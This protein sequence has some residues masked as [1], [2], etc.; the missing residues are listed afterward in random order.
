MTLAKPSRTVVSASC[1]ASKS[2]R[3]RDRQASRNWL[4]ADVLKDARRWWLIGGSKD[5]RSFG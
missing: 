2:P 4:W 1:A 3:L 5:H